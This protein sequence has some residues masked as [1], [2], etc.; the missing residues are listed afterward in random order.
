MELLK[1]EGKDAD[2]DWVAEWTTRLDSYAY[3]C[4]GESRW[5][6]I[7]GLLDPALFTWL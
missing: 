3:S 2:W 5:E 1:L 7:A 4:S 6:E